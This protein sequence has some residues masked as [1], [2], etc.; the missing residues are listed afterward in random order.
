MNFKQALVCLSKGEKVQCDCF[1][2][3]WYWHSP[4]PGLDGIYTPSLD[5]VML[6]GHRE[7]LRYLEGNWELVKK[8][9]SCMQALRKLFNGEVMIY[10]STNLRYK[11]ENDELM[12]DY[13]GTWTK[14]TVPLGNLSGTWTKPTV[15]LGNLNGKWVQV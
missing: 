12:F 9:Y 10:I 11:I 13:C 14:S 2:H 1:A 5:K 15:P 7:I 4:Y 6:D 8:Q 3:D